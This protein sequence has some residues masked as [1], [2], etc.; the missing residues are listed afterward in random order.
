MSE[1]RL[2]ALTANDTQATFLFPNVILFVKSFYILFWGSR[3][4]ELYK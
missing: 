1:H 4:R 2:D 3:V